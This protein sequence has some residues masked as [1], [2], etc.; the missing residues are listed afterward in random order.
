MQKSFNTKSKFFLAFFVS[1]T[2]ASLQAAQPS[3]N[4]NIE[5]INS[6]QLSHV[7]SS[8]NPQEQEQFVKILEEV[9]CISATNK[10]KDENQLLKRIQTI[11][12]KVPYS[13]L[14][15]IGLRL[16]LAIFYWSYIQP[17][18]E[19]QFPNSGTAKELP[20]MLAGSLIIEGI[21]DFLKEVRIIIDG[22]FSEF[23]TGQSSQNDA[24]AQEAAVA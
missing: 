1:L 14:S 24:I 5:N 10:I 15:G 21:K 13:Q 11:F 22:S 18:I 2:T 7:L 19:K 3:L 9:A 20:K 4:I 23:F 12:S 17:E 6:E 8:M 16:A